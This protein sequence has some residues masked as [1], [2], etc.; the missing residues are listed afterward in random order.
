MF[1]AQLRLW[2]ISASILLIFVACGAGA[3]TPGAPANSLAHIERTPVRVARG[4]YLVEGLAHCF[5]CHSENDFQHLNG[6]APPEK[7]GAGQIIPAQEFSEPIP[8]RMVCPNITPDPETGA[9]NWADED[10][11]RAIRQ[12]IGHDGRTLHSL[13]PYWTLRV[14]TDE[15]LAS[16]IAY[17]RSLPA[18]RHTLPTRSLA[19]DPVILDQPPLPTPPAPAGASEQVRHGEYLAHI[20]NCAGCHNARTP[21]GKPVSGYEYGGGRVLRGR[22]GV[23]TSQNITPDAS[24]IGYYD[25]HKFIQV[26]R[27]GHVGAR[28]LNSIMPWAD[29]R[30]LTDSDLK[31]LFAYLRTVPAVQH[32]VDNTEPPTFCSKCRNFHG[33]GDRN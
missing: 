9:G 17:V 26:M 14:L 30:N 32:R 1:T 20:G 19:H 7:K 3:G 33:F 11:V 16:V 12:G 4:K 8:S 15:D 24:G 31:A 10:F 28:K 13:M 18:V 27:T 25:E 6:Q 21:E 2:K 29:F 23:V 5:R 22:W